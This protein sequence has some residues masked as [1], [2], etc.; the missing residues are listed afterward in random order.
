MTLF[1]ARNGAIWVGTH[2]GGANVLDP[3]SG[4]IR[5]LPY[6]SGAPG[7][8]SSPHVTAIAQD[9][10]GNLWM[11]T[12]GGGLD[13]ARADGTVV[14]VFRHDARDPGTLPANTVYAH[15]PPARRPCLRAASPGRARRGGT[16]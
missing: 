1:E 2:G 8:L 13:L 4:R 10:H 16:L 11:G 9:S 12:D 5:Q 14:K 7:A 6:G 3:A 15:P